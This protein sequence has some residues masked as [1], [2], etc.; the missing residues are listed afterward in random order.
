[1]REVELKAQRDKEARESSQVWEL[2][3]REKA[4]IEQLNQNETN[5]V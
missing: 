3:D 5:N 1:V 2:S 4:I